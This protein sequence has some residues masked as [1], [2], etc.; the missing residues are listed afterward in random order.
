MGRGREVESR[1][2]ERR[3]EVGSGRG[4]GKG[5]ELRSGREG[6]AAVGARAQAFEILGLQICE[7]VPVI[8]TERQL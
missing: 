1:R 5:G 6:T 7:F 2:E 3:C 4:T 8:L